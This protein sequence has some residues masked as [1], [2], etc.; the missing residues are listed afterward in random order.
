MRVVVTGS[1]GFIGQALARALVDVGHE[2][3]G[4]DRARTRGLMGRATQE[5]CDVLDRT[6]L[7]GIFRAFAPKAVVHLAARTDLGETRD[8]AGYA[9]NIEGVRN[10]TDAVRETTEIE[11]AI[12]TSSQLVCRLG[13]MPSS[14]TDYAPDTL[15]G[16]SKVLTERIVRDSDGGG[17]PWCLVR[18]T[19]VWGPGMNPHY[20]GFL[21]MIQRGR[22]IHVGREPIWK[23]YGY[24]GNVVQEYLSLLQAEPQQIARKTLYLGDYQ[25]MSLRVWA[26]G[27]QRALGAPP[28]RSMP[29]GVAVAVA[30]GGDW[31]NALGWRA[32][33]FNS[34]R[35]GNVTTES[36]YDLRETE[37]I[38][39]P[40]PYTMEMGIEETTRWFRN[41]Q[42]ASGHNG[43]STHDSGSL[44]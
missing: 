17:V 4:V 38:C 26:D 21:R 42:P 27:F 16:E 44:S 2:V 9:A 7:I 36:V 29:R 8:L 31:L 12:F 39:G 1:S 20:Q 40:L 22:Y 32:F 19:T 23:T 28:I 18:P 24:I 15:Y 14:E 11:R 25:P 6:R 33:P 5:I 43:P 37:S 35:L 41:H 30:R 13:Y 34:F 3:L 10:V